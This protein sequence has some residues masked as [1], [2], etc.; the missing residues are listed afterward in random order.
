MNTRPFAVFFLLLL[1]A[2]ALSAQDKT[3]VTK[4]GEDENVQ[5]KTIQDVATRLFSVQN[6]E[7][8]K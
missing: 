4:N 2:P 6:A 8:L 7:V 5:S 1:L 3:V